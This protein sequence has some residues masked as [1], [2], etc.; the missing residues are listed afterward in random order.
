MSLLSR[1]QGRCRWN[2]GTIT[3]LGN[4]RSREFDTVQSDGDS[5]TETYALFTCTSVRV[6]LGTRDGDDRR[7][8]LPRAQPM[9]EVNLWIGNGCNLSDMEVL[10]SDN[11]NDRLAPQN[12]ERTAT[13][14]QSDRS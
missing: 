11:V 14:P 8:A 12:S 13:S 5:R 7:P 3:T 1:C 6:T 4:L 2:T 9:A 10:D